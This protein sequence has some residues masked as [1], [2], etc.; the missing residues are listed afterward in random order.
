MMVVSV[1]YD[2]T[3]VVCTRN[4][5]GPMVVVPLKTVDYLAVFAGPS[6]V[7]TVPVV[8]VLQHVD[9]I[10]DEKVDVETQLAVVNIRAPVQHPLIGGLEGSPL[11]QLMRV[12]T[13]AVELTMA[14]MVEALLMNQ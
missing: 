6:L 3:V 1:S 14:E 12:D 8:S 2:P 7:Q 4:V 5:A 13:M 9:E 11:D 10:L